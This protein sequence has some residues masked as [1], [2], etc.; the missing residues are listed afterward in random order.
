MRAQE[1]LVIRTRSLR[2]VKKTEKDSAE[3]PRQSR[4]WG[5]AQ[6]FVEVEPSSVREKA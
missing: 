3:A 4:G 6:R 5:R 2:L 1:R